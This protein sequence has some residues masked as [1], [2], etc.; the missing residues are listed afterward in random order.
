MLGAG[1]LGAVQRSHKAHSLG[2]T[3]PSPG[4]GGIGVKLQALRGMREARCYSRLPS[5]GQSTSSPWAALSSPSLFCKMGPMNTHL[6]GCSRLDSGAAASL[7]AWLGSSQES[8]L[9]WPRH[10]G[11][12]L[13]AGSRYPVPVA[14]AHSFLAVSL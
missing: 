2:R 6:G 10:C 7:P 4:L 3:G 9:R 13:T 14:D 1:M 12:Q 5:S 11:Q 8:S